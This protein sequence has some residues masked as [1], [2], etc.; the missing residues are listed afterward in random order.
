MNNSV[1]IKHKANKDGKLND[2]VI[3]V[4]LVF[5]VLWRTPIVSYYMNTYLA[6][7]ALVLLTVL[8]AFYDAKYFAGTPR[9][10]I[11]LIPFLLLTIGDQFLM[12]A[13]TSNSVVNVIWLIFLEVMPIFVGSLLVHNKMDFAIKALVPTIIVSHIVTAF[14]TYLGLLRFPEASRIMATGGTHFEKYYVYNIGSFAF[15][16]SLVLLHPLFVGYFRTRGRYV[17]SALTTV[18]TAFCVIESEYTTAMLLFILSCVA[19]FLPTKSDSRLNQ[20]RL[21][22]IMVFLLVMLLMLPILLN[23]L[24]ELD[25]LESSSEKLRDV[26]GLLQGREAEGKSVLARQEVYSRSWKAFKSSPI[27]GVGLFGGGS[28][29]HSYLIDTLAK[30]GILGLAFVLWFLFTFRREY[31]LIT[32]GSSVYYY[33]VLFFVLVLL[34][35]ILNP[36]SWTYQLGFAAPILIYRTVNMNPKLS[37]TE[38]K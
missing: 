14:T 35:C 32:K 10:I 20:K 33:S 8:V 27:I 17:L 34:L 11:A 28:G 36:K 7:M 9:V 19:Y 26:A 4:L 24:A 25:A 38:E 30:W 23:A 29:G 22:L 5:Y 12:G 1:Y 3:T 15:I 37:E 21:T 31:K 16:Y 2:I 13:T 18:I 6:M